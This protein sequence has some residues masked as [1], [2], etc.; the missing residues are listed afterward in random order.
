M[1]YFCRVKAFHHDSFEKFN[2][3][4]IIQQCPSEHQK[5]LRIK[6]NTDFLTN[7][8]TVLLEQFIQFSLYN[9]VCYYFD[10]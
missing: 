9:L 2:G 1:G 4:I 7:G 6:V 10:I 8:Y 3:Q 5:G